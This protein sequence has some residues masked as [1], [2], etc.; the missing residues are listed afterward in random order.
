MTKLK[1]IIIDRGI[2]QRGLYNLVNK[3]CKTPIGY[4]RISKIV[5]GK[6]TNYSL[7]TCLKICIALDLT[8]NDIIEREPFMTE[9]CY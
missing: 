9:E 7:H 8:P 5:N 1:K 2:S 6:T 3:K 4:D